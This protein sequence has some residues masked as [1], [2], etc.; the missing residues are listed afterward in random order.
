MLELNQLVVSWFNCNLK[1]EDAMQPERDVQFDAR[2][3]Q[4]VLSNI[5]QAVGAESDNQKELA[6]VFGTSQG[7]ISKVIQSGAISSKLY[8]RI[9]AT[10]KDIVPSTT[11]DL[12][13]PFVLNEV[14]WGNSVDKRRVSLPG[15]VLLGVEPATVLSFVPVSI[16]RNLSGVVKTKRV[17]ALIVDSRGRTIVELKTGRR[18][19]WG[20]MNPPLHPCTTHEKGQSILDVVREDVFFSDFVD[21]LAH[22]EDARERELFLAVT[23]SSGYHLTIRA[24]LQIER[25]CSECDALDQQGIAPPSNG[26]WD[27]YP[28]GDVSCRG[29]CLNKKARGICYLHPNT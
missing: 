8:L 5:A 7:T 21:K 16:I 13:V 23:G 26:M 28:L 12:L 10:A 6:R 1:T 9:V 20:G 11:L 18:E 25:S 27:I 2:I 3:L 22:H 15:K 14:D 29:E 4:A 19:C 17:M 24:G